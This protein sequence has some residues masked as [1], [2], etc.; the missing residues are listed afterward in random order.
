MKNKLENKCKEVDISNRERG[1]R[2]P[3]LLKKCGSKK[4]WTKK[5]YINPST[6]NLNFYFQYI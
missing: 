6:A 2:I 4:R 1:T 5:Q 3:K